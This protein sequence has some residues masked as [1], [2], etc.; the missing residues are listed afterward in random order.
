MF[1]K[2]KTTPVSQ[3]GKPAE[4]RQLL[5]AELALVSGGLNPQPLPPSPPNERKATRF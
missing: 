2:T 3:A 5:S 1:R 4:M